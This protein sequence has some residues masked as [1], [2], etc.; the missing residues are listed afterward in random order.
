MRK[1]N[2]TNTI[3]EQFLFQVCELNSAISMVSGRW[4]CQIVFSISQ[5]CNRFHLLKK[6][7]PKIS[8]QVLSRQL[9]ELETHAI[10]VK[11]EI[12]ETVPVGIEYLLTNKGLDLVP[13]LDGLCHWGKLY[14]GGK[15]ISARLT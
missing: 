6:K 3:N 9:K 15:E 11:K 14:A 13:I 2:S 1:E 4:K 10:L 5:G 12:P 7:L 8:E